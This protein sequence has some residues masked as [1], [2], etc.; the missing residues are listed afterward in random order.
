MKPKSGIT[1]EELIKWGGAEVFNQAL[2]LV[3]SGD[4]LEVEYDD[5]NLEIRGKIEQHDGWGMPVTLKLERE[6]RVRSLC[7]C[8]TNQVYHQICSHVVALGIAIMAMEMDEDED[9]G[10]GSRAKGRGKR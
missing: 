1:R 9:E 10:Q 6:G 2:A 8:R 7:P 4:V 3:N 5:E